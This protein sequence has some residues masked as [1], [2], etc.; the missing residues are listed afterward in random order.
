[1]KPTRSVLFVPGNRP[2]WITNAATHGA[3]LII[4]DL[5]DAVPSDETA[6]ARDSVADA[7]RRF[8]TMDN[9]SLSALTDIRTHQPTVPP[10]TFEE[11]VPQEPD[12]LVV[13][14]VRNRR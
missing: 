6:A 12:G 5:E 7:I 9:E 13:P 10:G 1:M 3:D 4:I 14:K 8:M 2:K 11:I